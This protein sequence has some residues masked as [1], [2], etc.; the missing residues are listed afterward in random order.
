MRISDWSS[1]V[2]SSD[3]YPVQTRNVLIED[4]V[5]IG[6]SDAGIYV[7]Q[8]QDVVVRRNRAEKNVA[9]IEIENCIGADV[10]D[11]VTTGNT[12]GILVFNMPD[13]PQPGHTTRVFNNRIVANNTDNFGR[14][15][16]AVAEVPAGRSQERG[17]GTD[18]VRTCGT[19]GS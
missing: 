1:D 11:N 5:V 17:G 10:Y 8:S 18:G 16:T 7:G 9:G 2:C 6:A 14:P 13:L 4:S 15:G 3:L 12:G 19:R